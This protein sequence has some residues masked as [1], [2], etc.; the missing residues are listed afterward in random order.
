MARFHFK[1]TFPFFTFKST[2][3]G[4]VDLRRGD[5]FYAVSGLGS[6]NAAVKDPTTIAGQ[7]YAYNYSSAV[8]TVIN[9]KVRA[10]INGIWTIQDNQGNDASAQADRISQ[11]LI[12][13]NV[14]Q[15]WAEF[16]S[17]MKLLSQ[18]FGEVL[19]LP[20]VPAGFDRLQTASMWVIPNWMWKA[21]KTGKFFFQTD[22]SEVIS[23]YEINNQKGTK[24]NILPTEVIHVRDLTAPVTTNNEELFNGQS[25]LF[26]LKWP[27]WN[28]HA[29]MEGR[30][31]MMT[32]RGAIGIITNDTEDIAGSIPIEPSE[33][34]NIEDN[35]GSYGLT[36]AQ[37]QV[38]ITSAKLKWQ[39]MAFATKDLMLHEET[40]ESTIMIADA[41][42]VPPDLL[43]AGKDDRT[44][45]NVTAAEKGLYQNA[46]IPESQPFAESF[47]NWFFRGL[48]LKFAIAFDH[49]EVFKKAKKDEADAIKSLNDAMKVAYEQ[50]IIT[51]EEWRMFLEQFTGETYGFDADDPI[52]TTYAGEQ[53]ITQLQL[54]TTPP[55]PTNR[56]DG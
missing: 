31:V 23:H 41:F 22:I 46:I 16:N 12:R 17:Q 32:Q 13:P 7:A 19:I 33:K 34:K 45:E 42:D 26:P 28:I 29:A 53:P 37:S 25:R 27:I 50:K 6:S 18:V 21:V 40:A 52:G 3:L 39:P 43:G 2:V 55:E 11:L 56:T 20:V 24:I 4:T 51:K 49:L 36:Q 8:N 48:A 47:T 38:I 54:T 9:R 14:I 5:G 30:N 1:R 35:F 15:S 44:Y 10:H